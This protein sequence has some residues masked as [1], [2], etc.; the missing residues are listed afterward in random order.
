MQQAQLN[1]AQR[2]IYMASGKY[3]YGIGI[4]HCTLNERVGL[5]LVLSLMQEVII[6]THLLCLC[7]IMDLLLNPALVP[8]TLAGTAAAAAAHPQHAYRRKL[9]LDIPRR[10]RATM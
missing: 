1:N 8:E 2:A 5:V 4:G 9:E 6:H 3:L 10:E 7:C